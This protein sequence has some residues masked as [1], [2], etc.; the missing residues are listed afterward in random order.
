[1]YSLLELSD[2]SKGRAKAVQ[3]HRPGQRDATHPLKVH[4]GMRIGILATDGIGD[5][6]CASGLVTDIRRAW[7][8]AEICMI[9]RFRETASLFREAS[10]IDD[11]IVYDPARGNSPAR[12]LKLI[13]EIR[14][15]RFDVF[16]T[17]TDIDRHKAPCLTFVS[18]A[19][20]RVGEAASRLAWLYTRSVPR[21]SSEHKV[22]SNRR[23]VSLLGIEASSPPHVAIDAADAKAVDDLLAS[24]GVGP[25]VQL[26]AVHPGSGAA[27]WHKRWA[28]DDY[29]AML[30]A[31]S[32]QHVRLL[33]VGAGADVPLCDA[34]VARLGNMVLSFAGKLSL[35]H[36]AALLAKCAVAVGADS[37]VM[38]LAAAVGTPTICLFGPTNERRTAPF[39][40]T[41]ILSADLSCRPC[42]PNLPH[43]CGNP[44]CMSGIS[45]ANVVAEV[46]N[47]LPRP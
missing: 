5:V 27:E 21:D 14:R 35:T 6:I 34:L 43:G 31:I 1:M 19:T 7:P 4:A 11:V 46:N 25:S 16:V 39:A 20:V 41:R 37:G 29:E 24:A 40:A 22:K 13:Y 38:H 44:V 15:R 17:V 18:G 33:L 42:Y 3:S 12:V 10:R 9:M 26:V 23:I 28:V 45:V 30:R 2:H 36:S 32:N 47:L 8:D